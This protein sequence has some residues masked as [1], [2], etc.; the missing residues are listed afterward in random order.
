MKTHLI[1]LAGLVCLA[2]C[3]HK[4]A[5]GSRALPQPIFRSDMSIWVDYVNNL[6]A[7]GTKEL[8]SE[9]DRLRRINDRGWDDELRFSLANS[10][11]SL[12]AH[13][14][15]K[16]AEIIGHASGKV[17][18]NSDLKAWLR[19]Y[20]QQMNTLAQLDKELTEEKRQRTEL[21]KK[22]KALSDIERDISERSKN[23]DIARP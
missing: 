16:A 5:E 9:Y 1:F 15:Q 22:L 18:G 8:K 12:K 13:N 3:V 10:V 19:L 4:G 6:E 20:G 11:Q 23:T 7:L 14:Y 17:Q 21:E 2:S